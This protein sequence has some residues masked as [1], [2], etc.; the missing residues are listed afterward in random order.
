[1]TRK[2]H[3]DWDCSRSSER[4]LPEPAFTLTEPLPDTGVWRSMFRRVLSMLR[5]D[6]RIKVRTGYQDETGFHG[7]IKPVE[8][9]IQWPPVW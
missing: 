9:G 4:T 3:S 5:K 8:N 6:V 1:M 2:T 7:G